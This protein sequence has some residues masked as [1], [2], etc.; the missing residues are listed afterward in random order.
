[1]FKLYLEKEYYLANLILGVTLAVLGVRDALQYVIDK[2]VPWQF[3]L[4]N[5][6]AL[7]FKANSGAPTVI[8][9]GKFALCP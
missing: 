5:V 3:P 4:L 9:R 7:S 6:F 8:T 2:Y 1:M